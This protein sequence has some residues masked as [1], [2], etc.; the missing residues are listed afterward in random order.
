MQKVWIVGSK[1]SVGVA[2]TKLLDMRKYELLKTDKEEV[3]VTDKE[4]VRSYAAATR[5]D[6]I[7]NCAGIT[8]LE[9]CEQNPDLAYQVN[10]I[11]A[12]NLAVAANEIE[13]K[14][15][16]MS[17]DDI[18][19]LNSP[20]F[21]NEFEEAKPKSIYGKSKYAGEKMVQSLCNYFVIIRS[22]WVYGTGKGFVQQVIDA[23]DSQTPLRVPVNHYASPTSAKE[24]AKVIT[25][26]IDNDLF[27]IYHAV[28]KGY[29]NRYEFAKAI[30]KYLGKDVELI[31]IEEG[32]ERRPD[33]S[34]LDN[35]MLRLDG[36]EQP[37]KW[38]VALEEYISGLE[39]N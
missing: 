9:V 11:G 26:F 2:L 16:H 3:D 30:L 12:R 19:S 27:G 28:C 33:Y 22:S 8:D 4:E 1:G 32:N 36:L 13:C 31:P 39:R 37:K 35:M 20:E 15:I 14:L 38:E 18:F 24:L 10:T 7:I 21:Y 17:T 23:V 34:V 29:C 25:Q 5:P 6:V